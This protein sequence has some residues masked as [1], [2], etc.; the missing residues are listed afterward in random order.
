MSITRAAIENSVVTFVTLAVIYLG[1]IGAYQSLPR[2]E[3]PGFI[4]R[5]AVVTTMFPG[6]SP[7]R[8]ELL[9]TDKLEKVIQ[10]IPELDFISSESRT[11][12]SLVYANILESESDMRP[13]WDNL[14]RKMDRAR[15]DL[16]DGVIG[17]FVDDEF[18]DVFGTV[19][20]ITGEGF[21]YAA[22]KDIAD[23]A[24][25]E[26]LML[27]DVAKVAVFGAQEEQIFVEYN[28]ARLAELGL[29]P[30]QLQQA[31]AS[32]NI[33]IAGG[34]ITSGRERI[35][36]EPSG[37]FQSVDDIRRSILSI[38]GRNDLLFLED[39]ANVYRGYVDPPGA[40]CRLDGQ[41]ALALAISMREG[42]DIVGLGNQIQ[43][44]V[45][46]MQSI[47]PIGVDFRIE[48]F[49]PGIVDSIVRNF[50]G[51]LFQ[52]IGIVM[53]VML[54]S[55]GLRTG[56]IVASLIPSTMVLSFLVMSFFGQGLNQ[57]S[58]AALIIALG[59]LVD[60]AIVMSE[61]IM[62]RISDGESPAEA[63]VNSAK[64]L[65]VPLLTSSLTT[66]AAFLPIALAE[67]AVGEYT[68]PI[69]YVVT[70]ALLCSWLIAMTVIPLFCAKWLRVKPRPEGDAFLGRW[71]RGYRGALL[72]CARRP[73]VFLVA[74]VVLFAGV[75]QL[76]RFVPSIFFP[77]KDIA[78]FRAELEFPVGTDIDFTD[79][80]V[81]EVERFVQE[82]LV[83]SESPGVQHWITFV[84]QGGPR[85]QLGISP[86]PNNSAYAHLVFTGYE[87]EDHAAVIPRLEAFCHE[88]FPDLQITAGPI[89]NGPPVTNPVEVRIRGR[90]NDRVFAIVEQVKEQLARLPGT[91]S[92]D[93]DW[94]ARTKKL[95]V[96][97]DQARARR[98]GVTSHDIAVSLQ[99]SLSGL[100]LSEY[101]EGDKV[102]PINLR[103]IAADRQDLGKLEEL[104]V[105]AQA[106]GRSVPL[107]QVASVEVA[108]EPAQILRR[109][110]L[111]NVTVSCALEAGFTANEVFAAIEPWLLEQQGSWPAGYQWEF[112]GE[113][114]ASGTAQAS[115]M[116]KLPIAG[117]AIILLLVAQFNSV[118]KPAIIL[119]TIPLGLIGVIL[120]LLVA[121]S[122]FGF[123]TFLGVIS[124]SGIVINNAIVLID[125]IQIEIDE[126][127]SPGEAVLMAGQRRIRPILLTTMTTVGGLVPL[128]LGG[129][130]MFETMAIAILFGLMF[131]TVLTLAVV[132][133]LYTIFYRVSYDGV[134]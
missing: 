59:L 43:A 85:F 112:G 73:I 52:A 97:I 80:M 65:Q 87:R 17:P 126:G 33:L 6:A 131:A 103:S 68:A 13:I 76:M 82:E 115:V 70:I 35:A 118:R 18:G 77:G 64:E 86:E 99:T 30:G 31:L 42:G 57:M 19:I 7:E 51:N 55:L 54:L 130:P 132:P 93:D 129:G 134:R 34:E 2:A 46:R 23:E 21:D 108:W 48:L 133:V 116:A 9:V 119:L 127:L 1:G 106:T 49:Q 11:G 47:Y 3:D 74:V 101:R 111:Q 123:M 12:Q 98:A 61:S 36:L 122:Y 75:L 63:A 78:T 10:E 28:D 58:L 45:D 72:A 15:G 92:I 84:G 79:S 56:L 16:P 37:N 120:G 124:L 105:S 94:G 20:G 53:V 81:A 88:R 128:W 27:D 39:I 107:K 113:L 38:P 60:N 96:D 91:K 109:D 25:D 29:S 62:V 67:S 26:L 8:V 114:E 110:R 4:I 41:P 22:L 104:S 50:A 125:R 71:Y 14:R 44:T 102:I 117:L 5:T 40:F 69:F 32:I 66:A 24:R 89:M 83:T 100:Q 95:V 121:K 90:E